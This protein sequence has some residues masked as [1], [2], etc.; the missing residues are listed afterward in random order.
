LVAT[1]LV[2]TGE[3]LNLSLG[4]HRLIAGAVAAFV[5][6]RSRNTWLTILAGMGALWLMGQVI[7]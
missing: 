5:A 2:G 7:G 4:N 1:E 3:T 6:W